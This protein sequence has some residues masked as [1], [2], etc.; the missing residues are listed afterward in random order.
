MPKFVLEIY[1]VNKNSYDNFV[2]SIFFF[3]QQRFQKLLDKAKL[4]TFA[5]NKLIKALKALKAWASKD[6]VI[7]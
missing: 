7:D 5:D 3:S 6:L 4:K 2:Y 1:V